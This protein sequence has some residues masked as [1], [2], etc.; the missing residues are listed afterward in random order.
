MASPSHPFRAIGALLTAFVLSPVALLGVAGAAS[1]PGPMRP[2]WAVTALACGAGVVGS[3]L[4]VREVARA[5]REEAIRAREAREGGSGTLVLA[6]WRVDRTEARAFAAREWRGRKIEVVSMAGGILVLGGGLLWLTEDGP[7]WA[8]LAASGFVAALVLLVGLGKY[9]MEYR[10]AVSGSDEVVIFP[11][12]ALV[13][14]TWHALGGARSLTGAVLDGD[15]L[16]LS[17][18]WSTRD[19]ATVTDDIRVPVPSEARDAAGEAV[20]YLRGRLPA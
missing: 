4:T 11:D 6:R 20:A 1:D 9:G 16:V 17:V 2:L 5:G 7:G 3:L 13:L 15:A 12:S 8:A 14:G 10:A 18:R 19:G